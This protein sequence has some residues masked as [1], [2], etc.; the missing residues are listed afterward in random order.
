MQ[1]LRPHHLLMMTL[2]ALLKKKTGFGQCLAVFEGLVEAAVEQESHALKMKSLTQM[3][4]SAAI[5]NRDPV[6]FLGD[7]A[8][9]LHEVHTQTFEY[10]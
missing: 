7:R 10:L 2:L 5:V 9:L 3:P 8:E 6:V 1:E 4:P